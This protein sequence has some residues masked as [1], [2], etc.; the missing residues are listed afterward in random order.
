MKTAVDA[1]IQKAIDENKPEDIQL[2]KQVRSFNSNTMTIGVNASALDKDGNVLL[3]MTGIS[4]D[5][6]EPYD[7]GVGSVTVKASDITQY[8]NAV[9]N[10]TTGNFI[11]YVQA[12]ASNDDSA[13]TTL[14]VDGTKAY[15]AGWIKGYNDAAAMFED[16]RG[17][18]NYYAYIYGPASTST[19]DVKNRARFPLDY[20]A[21]SHG[22]ESQHGYSESKLTINN[23]NITN[24]E[25]TIGT[26]VVHYTKSTYNP[27]TSA[28][29]RS[30]FE[31]KKKESV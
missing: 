11:V 26:S 19:Y 5:A 12:V 27:G 24:Y 18:S 16:R 17:D 7:A 22:T 28:Y 29:K 20:N 10:S 23:V 2:A 3:R 6:K 15:Q 14:S 31:I 1:L 9:Y 25:T 8:Q 4:V 13:K 21:S 30:S